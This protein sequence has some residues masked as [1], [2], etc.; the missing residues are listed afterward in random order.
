[1]E[2]L[3]PVPTPLAEAQSILQLPWAPSVLSKG[4]S[5]SQRCQWFSLSPLTPH[6]D[7]RTSVTH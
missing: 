5:C 1:M 3:C 7:E 6:P 4:L 2:G